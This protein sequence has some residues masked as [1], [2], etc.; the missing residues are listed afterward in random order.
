[1]EEKERELVASL[2]K[3]IDALTRKV[4]DTDFRLTRLEANFILE[5]QR[6]KEKRYFE[7]NSVNDILYSDNSIGKVITDLPP[8]DIEIP[9]LPSK[10]QCL[11]SI[12]QKQENL[13]PKDEILPISPQVK[14]EILP[15]ISAQ[16]P[17]NSQSIPS[18][19][20][21][22]KKEEVKRDPISLNKNKESPPKIIKEEN[23]NRYQKTTEGFFDRF[24]GKSLADLEIMFG[25]NLLNKIGVFIFVL[26]IVFLMAWARK[27]FTL[28]KTGKI[29]F[30][31]LVSLSMV[32]GGVWSEKK[33]KYVY[34]GHSLIAGGWALLYFTTYAIFNIKAVK[35]FD[36]PI[37]CTILL[38]VVAIGMIS[39]SLKYE[40]EWITLITYS[41]GFITL[42]LIEVTPLSLVG[43]AILAISLI[44]IS[45]KLDWG[46]LKL[47]GVIACYF[48][49]GYWFSKVG[50]FNSSVY[51]L[52]ATLVSIYW[53]TFFLPF[54]IFISCNDDQL[55]EPIIITNM[56]NTLAYILCF[57]LLMEKVY[58]H[59]LYVF[60]GMAG[61]FYLVSSAWVRTKDIPHL[62]YING[63]VSSILFII[64]APN[65]LDGIQIT[66]CWIIIS[67]VI[68]IIGARLKEEYFRELGFFLIFA[69]SIRL[70]FIDLYKAD[71]LPLFSGFLSW[72]ILVGTLFICANY[73]MAWNAHNQ[74]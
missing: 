33:E 5:N 70:L 66:L 35:V 72:R 26:G 61:I 2:I 52:G 32:I 36:N 53:F 57:S 25:G 56:I 12:P 19:L 71:R 3:I 9:S 41:L 30:G 73:Y 20:P 15:I 4:E 22:L 28:G 46:H 48:I 16:V 14:E 60:W 11:K 63:T 29:I 1:M 45:S 39:H 65:K 58:P 62:F 42:V 34:Y 7:E 50:I 6:T 24:K 17:D 40:N 18:A 27:Y 67:Q 54:N 31:Y 8:L 23:S 49:W 44:I 13:Y 68:Y 51:Y 64:A 21:Y 69:P 55:N 37:M 59:Y 38:T 43:T 74:T 10:P 47:F